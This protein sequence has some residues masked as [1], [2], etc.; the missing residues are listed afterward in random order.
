MPLRLPLLCSLVFAA[1]VSPAT[2]EPTW[3]AGTASAIITPQTSMWMGG[4]ASRTEPS[5]GTDLDLKA[6]ALVLEDAA[7]QRAALVCLDLISIP[8]DL[9]LAVAAALEKAH[10]I[11]IER[12]MLNAS[13][14]HCGPELRSHRTKGTDQPAQRDEEAQRYRQRLFETILRLVSTAI[15]QARPATLDYHQARCGFAMNRRLNR[16]GRWQNAPNPDGPVDHRV[17]VLCVRDA[18]KNLV[19]LAFGYACH[20]TTQ[21]FQK[22]SGD[23]AGHACRL[24]EEQHPGCT[25]LFVNGCSG[26]QNPYPRR[27][28]GLEKIHGQTLATAVAAA[29]Q[30]P[31]QPLTGGLSAA[32]Q[33]IPLAYEKV[34]TADGLRQ[35]LQDP[36]RY[37][38][39]RARALLD[40]LEAGETLP[41]SYP[42]PV[43]V[44]RLGDQLTLV[45]LGGEVVVDY[46]L[47]LQRELRDAIVWVAGYSNDVMTY[48]PSQRVWE[49]GG[50]EGGDAM[51]YNNH[52]SRWASGVE[53]QIIQTI[54]TLRNSLPTAPSR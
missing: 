50:Y 10:G 36:D 13:H 24:L 23:Y 15:T 35:H 45:A 14:T 12:L 27:E 38:A 49:E 16:L 52:P 17:P 47:R 54:Q 3:K 4:Y 48:I 42:Y 39:R 8:R 53:D 19:A 18:E 37:E 25:A 7:G 29:L 11:P 41:T 46:S 33:E 31:A 34:P 30:T 28:P 44:L 43:Q 32:Y 21:S 1:F 51:K 26:D 6:S 5:D 2:A 20:C 9:H 22:F 40:Q